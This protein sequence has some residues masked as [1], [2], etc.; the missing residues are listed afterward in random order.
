MIGCREKANF[1]H[2]GP[3]LIGGTPSEGGLS[4]GYWPY[5][6]EF[7]RKTKKSEWIGSQAR[8]STE[9]VISRLPV[10]AHKCSATGMASF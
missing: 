7:R 8:T 1:P 10:R 9:P 6:R 2:A 5:L 3:G 4:K